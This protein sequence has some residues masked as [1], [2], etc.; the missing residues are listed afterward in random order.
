MSRESVLIVVG[1]LV[2]ISPFSGLPVSW[3]VWILPIM[4]AIVAVIGMTYKAQSV[5]ATIPALEDETA[6]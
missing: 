3:L 6:S 5:L 2:A 4:G 1:I